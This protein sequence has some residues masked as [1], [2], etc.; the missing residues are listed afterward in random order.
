MGCERHVAGGW[1][2]WAGVHEI[3]AR[4][5]HKTLGKRRHTAKADQ[6]RL[7]Q[8]ATGGSWGLT[9]GVAEPIKAQCAPFCVLQSGAFLLRGPMP[10]KLRCPTLALATTL[11]MAVSV[12][13]QAAPA[14]QMDRLQAHCPL[15]AA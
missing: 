1:Q 6:E 9:A 12:N 3:Q 15:D 4:S 5:G 11:T 8:R 13:A 7:A 14:H 10:I 2:S